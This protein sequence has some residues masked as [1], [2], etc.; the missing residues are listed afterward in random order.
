[1]TGPTAVEGSAVG[2]LASWANGLDGWVRVIASRVLARRTALDDDTIEVGYQEMLA[3]KGLSSE[4]PKSAPAIEITEAPP[5][6]APP[7]RLIRIGET[8]HVNRLVDGQEISFNNRITVVYGENASGKTGYARVLKQ[9]AGARSAGR[10]LPDVYTSSP[11]TPTATIEY[12]LG[13]NMEAVAWL[14]GSPAVPDLGRVCVF[15]APAAPLHVD[16]DLTYLYTPADIALFEYA[17]AA[18]SKV[19]DLLTAERARRAPKGNPFLSRFRRGTPQF[20]LVES[21]RASTDLAELQRLAEI[22]EGEDARVAGLGDRVRNLESVGQQ[23][24]L[25]G[26]RASQTMFA[27]AAAIADRLL[28]FDAEK[29][30]NALD[31]V[32][33]RLKRV[34]DVSEALF[35]GDDLPGLFTPEWTAF[36]TAA[37][38]Y[39][40]THLQPAFP[41]GTADCPY[42]RQALGDVSRELLQRYK[43]YLVDDSQA[44]LRTAAQSLT[45][46]VAPVADMTLPDESVP[47]G[48]GG[49]GDDGV[50]DAI[51]RVRAL[52]LR[53]QGRLSDRQPW[54]LDV[55]I[56]QLRE[57]RRMLVERHDAAAR[58]VR[59]LSTEASERDKQLSEARANL[60]ELEDRRTLRSLLDSIVEHV[61]AAKWVDLADTVLRTFQGL[62]RSLTDAMK[63]A[64]RGI[65]NTTFESA[66]QRECQLLSCPSVRLEFPGRQAATLR[67]KSV[68]DNYRLGEVLS[69]GEQKVIALADFLAEVS[70][71]PSSAPIILDDPITSLDA[72]RV[73]EVA[74]RIVNLS[75][76]Q[77]VIVFTH[78]L[79][80][81]TKLIAAFEQSSSRSHCSFYEV[82]AEDGKV[83]L[84]ARGSHPRMDTVKAIAGRVNK[85]LQDARAASGA[86]RSDLIA[87]AYG[88]M[89]AWIEAFIEDELL[90]G[91]VK[92]HR[93]NISIDALSRVNGQAVDESVRILQPIFDRAC[94]RMW[95]HAHTADQLQ[96]R[97]TIE[98]VDADW[99]AL[100][101]VA[102]AV[103]DG[104][105]PITP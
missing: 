66:F 12:S 101:A 104:T 99:Q 37:H 60:L 53:Q 39:G 32:A 55:D 71:Q 43:T 70:L 87:T 68:G 18:L 1:V 34:Q 57:D 51:S 62:L 73:D 19:R 75:A 13:S 93:A 56:E 90:Q 67:H 49:D 6:D 48:D 54:D 44:A 105:F 8:S 36:I 2:A 47:N 91:S 61:E 40:V 35:S 7:L 22:I 97:P 26:A 89:R 21:L 38:E 95:P 63:D 102:D 85:A 88:H 96:A 92:R 94:E 83:G 72:R 33:A 98:E 31:D 16:D 11:G 42:C 5:D 29:Y 14:D 69:E 80:F 46:L 30:A 82:L 76:E 81:A 23:V 74:E 79:Y 9:V 4:A 45:E 86:V 65:L 3:E 103:K 78:H 20:A 28:G 41:D 77:Q 100:K 50:A 59:D 27:S 17:H 15:D 24:Q 25:A 64:T 52:G 10:V 84:V 58:A